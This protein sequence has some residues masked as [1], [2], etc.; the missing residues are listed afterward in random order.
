MATFNEIEQARNVKKDMFQEKIQK[1]YE[2]EYIKAKSNIPDN[3]VTIRTVTFGE[4]KEFVE[5]NFYL[6]GFNYLYFRANTP[7]NR[8]LVKEL[9]CKHD[10]YWGYIINIEKIGQM[11]NGDFEIQN[12]AFSAVCKHLNTFGYKV[13][14]YQ[15]LD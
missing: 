6:C 10:P 11:G 5:K 13:N 9:N 15:N 12:K 8:K 14:L 1:L 7:E 3:E 2:K 4:E